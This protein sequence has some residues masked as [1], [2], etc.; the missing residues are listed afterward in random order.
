MIEGIPLKKKY[1]WVASLALMMACAATYNRPLITRGLPANERKDYIVQNGYG[2]PET[3][4]QSFLE[5]FVLPG[6]SKELVFQLY[7]APDRSGDSDS[8]WEYVNGK[9]VIVTAFKFKGDKV[10]SLIGD[11]RGGYNEAN[12]K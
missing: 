10:D 2:I 7:G 8:Y 1:I 4:K 3:L 11:P 5:G 6:M 12:G 9:G